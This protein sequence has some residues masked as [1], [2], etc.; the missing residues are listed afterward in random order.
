M[1]VNREQRTFEGQN[2]FV[3]L[4][5]KIAWQRTVVD[6]HQKLVSRQV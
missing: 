6:A 3:A 4:S 2:V 1:L 5:R